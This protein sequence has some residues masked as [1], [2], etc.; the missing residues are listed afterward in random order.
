[1]NVW[2]KKN[3]EKFP[4]NSSTQKTFLTITTHTLSGSGLNTLLQY[5]SRLYYLL[6][7]PLPCGYLSVRGKATGVNPDRKSC[8]R[9]L[10]QGR[11]HSAPPVVLAICCVLL[12]A[13]QLSVSL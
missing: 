3:A 11:L 2:F 5:D 6:L 9:I 1:M 12:S 4:L 10:Q 7:F 8:S 13:V